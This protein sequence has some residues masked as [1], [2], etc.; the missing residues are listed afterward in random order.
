MSSAAAGSLRHSVRSLPRGVWFLFL[1][2]FVNRFGTF[3]VPFLVLYLTHMGFSI[4][5]AG[6][7]AG[8]YGIGHIAA[9]ILGG[10]LADHF[11]RRNT[12]AL[13][14]FSTAIALMLL[15]QARGFG[16][17][18]AFA[19]LSGLAAEMYR[20]AAQAL[21][22]D[23]VPEQQ[24]LTAYS[25]YRLAANA[26]FAFG[27]AL[28]G[29]LAHR[30]Y[31]YLFAGDAATA[32]GYGIIALSLL[33]RA[34]T[35]TRSRTVGAWKGYGIA[36]RDRRLLF[37]L[38][39]SLAITFVIFQFG[40]T[41][42]LHVRDAGMTE[43]A[44]GLFLSLNGVLIVFFELPL[45]A[46]TR[47]YPPRRVIALGIL[48]LGIGFGGIGLARTPAAMVA[49]V[50]LWTLG[51]ITALP[52]LAAFVAN[53]APE[54]FRGR[55]M[56]LWGLSFSIGIAAGPWVGSLLYAWH[57]FVLWLLCP[58]LGFTSAVLV[59]FE[60]RSTERAAQGSGAVTP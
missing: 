13:S 22:A 16:W 14:M 23:L 24:R 52:L 20:P 60:P 17:I 18:V 40:S 48:L 28:A 45:T 29:F 9:S 34:S 36:M 15:Y 19:A 50:C 2:T 51:E 5:R 21:I 46:V 37:I 47:R 7:A 10:F 3:V 25:I 38:L 32:A 49:V 43:T 26:G 33:P 35:S 39:A 59:S 30:S 6:A 57:P 56:G 4:A 58:I 31:F 54:E 44:Y 42:P 41:V 27:P 53:L 55:Y 1:G 11:G 8:A 12:I